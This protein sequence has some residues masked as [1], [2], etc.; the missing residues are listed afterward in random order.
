MTQDEGESKKLRDIEERQNKYL[1]RRVEEHDQPLKQEEHVPDET[2]FPADILCRECA[3][4]A[5][6][7]HQLATPAAGG[8]TLA[9]GVFHWCGHETVN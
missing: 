6:G 5:V 2:E 7:C 8:Q 9:M 1:A 4:A 3:P